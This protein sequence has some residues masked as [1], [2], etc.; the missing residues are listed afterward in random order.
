M[1][2]NRPRI[3]LSLRGPVVARALGSMLFL[4]LGFSSWM[5]VARADSPS[6]SPSGALKPGQRVSQGSPPLPP[7]SF[8]PDPGPSP[9]RP[10]I[11]NEP[12][13]LMRRTYAPA[14][15]APQFNPDPGV[16]PVLPAPRYLIDFAAAPR[17]DEPSSGGLPNR[18]SGEI[19]RTELVWE[20]PPESTREHEDSLP[21]ELRLPRAGARAN[22]K[23]VSG[24]EL[25]QYTLAGGG[26]EHPPHASPRPDRWKIPFEPWRRYTTGQA[27]TPYATQGPRLWHPY[28]QSVLKGDAPIFGQ[29]LFLNL[30]ASV[31]SELEGRRFPVHNAALNGTTEQFLSQLYLGCSA[32]LFYGETSLKPPAWNL[33]IRPVFGVNH[34]ESRESGNAS[35]TSNAGIVERRLSRGGTFFALQECYVEKAL[36][37]VSDQYDLIALRVGNQ[38]FNSDFRGYIFNDINTGAR[39]FGN[40][41]NNRLQYNLALFDMREKETLTELNRFDERGQRVVVANLYL[42]DFLRPGYTAQWS[43]HAN[44]DSGGAHRDELGRAVRP[45][46]VAGA[47]EQEVR[48]VYLGWAGDGHLGRL[49]LSHALYQVLGSEEFNGLAGRAIDLNARMA[50]LEL[51]LDQDWLRYKAS[52]LYASGD[53]HLRDGRGGGFDG[54]LDSPAFAG[55]PFSFFGRH[56]FNLGGSTVNLKSRNSFFP[57]LRASKLEGQAN[58][59]NPGLML[60]GLG[61]DARLTQRLRAEVHANYVRLSETGALQEFL[62]MSES[63]HELG[64]DLSAGLTY[65]PMLTQNIVVQAGFGMLVPGQGWKDL[66]STAQRAGGIPCGALLTLQLTF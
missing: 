63:S 57:S 6:G 9:R 35:G 18:T 45:L 17:V 58:F 8:N 33:R 44:F 3:R 40:A 25:P 51:S 28:H 1:M 5:V 53:A 56:G 39:L 10:A 20:S 15:I 26:S 49:N 52:F 22:E 50:A 59:V 29:H 23:L 16:L 46:P 11:P 30:A 61:L 2:C 24:F 36:A 55:A 37:V 66:Y 38:P 42:Q 34:L 14:V 47:R 4:G 31:Q 7:S 27:E 54:I 65:R 41:F 62:G 21:A 12:R 13:L 19:S 43:V 60:L 32:D 48:A 64:V